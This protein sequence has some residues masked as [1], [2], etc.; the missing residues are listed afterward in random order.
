M[1]YLVVMDSL[2]Q[3]QRSIPHRQSAIFGH[4]QLAEPVLAHHRA[5]CANIPPRDWKS[6]RENL[7]Q[8]RAQPAEADLK[9]SN[10]SLSSALN[11]GQEWPN[12]SAQIHA[13]SYASVWESAHDDSIAVIYSVLIAFYRPFK[14]GSMRSMSRACLLLEFEPPI[15]CMSEHTEATMDSTNWAS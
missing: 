7:A 10:I 5:F 14:N 11:H 6:R 13:D 12:C 4:V 9:S 2:F 8:T 1:N 3:C 15:F